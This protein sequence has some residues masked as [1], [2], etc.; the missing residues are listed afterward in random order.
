MTL[1][2]LLRV[3]GVL[4]PSH[5]SGFALPVS[6][7]MD[8]SLHAAPVSLASFPDLG[9]CIC[10]LAMFIDV[11]GE[12]L[13]SHGKIRCQVIASGLSLHL[14]PDLRPGLLLTNMYAKLASPGAS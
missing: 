11:N 1:Y 2:F 6:G 3:I 5:S 4:R 12:C 9:V 7:C 8:A 10:T 13:S 14:P